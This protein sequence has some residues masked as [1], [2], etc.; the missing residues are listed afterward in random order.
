MAALTMTVGNVLALLQK[1]VKRLLAYSSIAHTGYML[2]ALLVGPVAGEGP[3]KDGVAALLFYVAVYGAM[4]LGAF[5]VLAAFKTGERPVETLDDL[6]GLASRAPAAALA[7]AVCAFSLMGIPP[8]AGFLGKLYVFSTAFS[9]DSAHP[10]HGPLIVLAVIGVVN[11][12]IGAAYYLRIVAA[13]Y[14]GTEI[15]KAVPT[16]GTPVRWGMA[17]CSLPL[18]VIFAWPGGLTGQARSATV[19]LL[20]PAESME[21]G[22]GAVAASRH[23]E[24]A[25]ATPQ[26]SVS[27][28]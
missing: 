19:S 13:A 21:E 7:L 1:N 23:R 8:T 4:N 2:I 9:L 15:E 11:A 5:A 16:G 27:G 25:D 28:P 26:P 6:S 12:A 20:A 18:L 10:F 3:M 14:L 22:G 17:L 24:G